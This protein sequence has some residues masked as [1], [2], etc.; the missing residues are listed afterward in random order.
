MLWLIVK[1][2]DWL[3]PEPIINTRLSE[4]LKQHQEKKKLA[5]IVPIRD[6]S[7]TPIPTDANHETSKHDRQQHEN[8]KDTEQTK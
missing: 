4:K 1:I 8:K 2:R 3:K 5:D 6:S 7:H